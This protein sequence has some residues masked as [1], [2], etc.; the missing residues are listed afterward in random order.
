MAASTQVLTESMNVV[1][2]TLEMAEIQYATVK[3]MSQDSASLS[4]IVKMMMVSLNASQMEHTG[5]VKPEQKESTKS[6]PSGIPEVKTEQAVIA[7]LFGKFLPACF[8]IVA[9]RRAF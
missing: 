6:G 9:M 3:A 7:R 1:Q 5:H 2:T 8:R 4:V